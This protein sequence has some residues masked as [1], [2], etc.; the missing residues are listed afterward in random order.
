MYYSVSIE[1]YTPLKPI[2]RKEV[3]SALDQEGFVAVLAMLDLSAAF[4][5]VGNAFL[6]SCLR[7]I[8]GIHNQGTDRQELGLVVP[9]Q[10]LG[11]SGTACIL[12][13]YSASFIC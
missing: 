1:Q 8:H 6:L 7:E 12:N 9:H 3:L 2:F 13:L 10:Y 11:R 5:N 4:D